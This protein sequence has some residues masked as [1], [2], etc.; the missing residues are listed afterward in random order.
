MTESIYMKNISTKLKK[1]YTIYIIIALMII[2]IVGMVN[3]WYCSVFEKQTDNVNEYVRDNVAGKMEEFY[4]QLYALSTNISRQSIIADVSRYSDE[5]EFYTSPKVMNIVSQL[6]NYKSIFGNID[7]IYVYMAKS[8][9]VISAGGVYD[10]RDFY[11]IYCAD[12]ISNYNK[13][14]ERIASDENEELFDCDESIQYNIMLNQV[15]VGIPEKVSCGILFNKDSI[16]PQTPW[17]EW[18]NRC[19]IYIYDINGRLSIYDERIDIQNLSKP[20]LL[21]NLS[22]VSGKYQIITRSIGSQYT[23]AIVF[24]KNLDIKTVKRVQMVSLLAVIFNIIIGIIVLCYLYVTKIRPLQMLARLLN[25]DIETINYKFLEKPIR[26]LIGVNK[27]LS[28]RLNDKNNSV[29]NLIFS[30]LLVGEIAE[31]YLEILAGYQIIF[32]K[33]NFVIVVFNIYKDNDISADEDERITADI[34]NFTK[35]MLSDECTN[36]YLTRVQN[37]LVCICNTDDDSEGCVRIIAQKFAYITNMLDDKY[38]FVAT[39]AVSERNEGIEGS[40]RGYLQALEVI[41][42]SELFDYNKVVLYSNVKRIVGGNE[43]VIDES[44]LVEAIK[45]GN[46]DEACAVIE[47]MFSYIDRNNSQLYCRISV[48]VVYTLMKTANMVWRK[49]VPMYEL[50]AALRDYSNIDRVKE[51]CVKA[52]KEQCEYMSKSS[53]V[54]DKGFVE[55]IKNY[56][57]ENYFDSSISNETLS[58]LVHYST[59]HINNLYK[60]SYGIT[61]MAYLTKYRLDMAKKFIADGMRI[62]DVSEKVGYASIRTF[63]RA[64]QNGVNMTPVEYKNHVLNDNDK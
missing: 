50:S 16:F 49:P 22:A 12:K 64:F 13:W 20:M 35:E 25:I 42:K 58:E 59:I 54:K 41:G 10:S 40:S 18:V 15:Y 38:N 21:S 28:R 37:R 26:E 14:R 53:N 24:E 11:D 4:N 46:A 6:D 17:V 19:N 2:Y 23:A 62:T 5:R 48:G 56:I 29:S 32:D 9:M 60:K 55:Y 34:T 30:K 8:D 1:W 61:P 7:L 43:V 31:E 27:E 39:V 45:Y 44:E 36:V 33:H 47:K 57:E 52:A 51:I 3:L 63:N